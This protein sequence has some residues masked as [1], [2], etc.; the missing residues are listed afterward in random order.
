MIL[1]LDFEEP[2]PK[3][4][5]T[6][7]DGHIDGIKAHLYDDYFSIE[8]CSTFYIHDS[9]Q[10]RKIQ[11]SCLNSYW[12]GFLNLCAAT[13]PSEPILKVDHLIEK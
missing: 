13:A 8:L 10:S 9:I 4:S 11:S 2:F 6:G 5:L 3:D 1:S 12:A 7:G